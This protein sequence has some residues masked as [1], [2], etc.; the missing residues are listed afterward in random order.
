MCRST[1]SI[2]HMAKGVGVPY[3]KA[4]KRVK[5]TST[6]LLEPL[7]RIPINTITNTNTKWDLED[8]FALATVYN[9][10]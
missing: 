7:I 8:S 1:C 4:T 9:H 3:I 2:H 10:S 5:H 6:S